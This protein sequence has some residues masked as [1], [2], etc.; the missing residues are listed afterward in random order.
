MHHDSL[1]SVA[2]VST[3]QKSV[4][5]KHQQTAAAT[6]TQNNKPSHRVFESHEAVAHPPSGGAVSADVGEGLVI[7]TVRSAEG[8]LLNG[9]VHNEVLRETETKKKNT[10]VT[11]DPGGQLTQRQLNKVMTNRKYRFSAA[12]T[13]SWADPTLDTLL[14]ASF[15]PLK[16][17]ILQPIYTSS[18]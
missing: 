5:W 16:P 13:S 7:V 10:E 14:S 6:R 12:H 11:Q 8:N 9:L 15:N 18:Q 3:L 1:G 17:L 4:K 2:F